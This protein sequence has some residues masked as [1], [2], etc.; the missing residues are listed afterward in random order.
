[1]AIFPGSITLFLGAR[2]ASQQKD[3]PWEREQLARKK[4]LIFEFLEVPIH[5]K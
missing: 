4:V 5:V 2:A 3:F 1:V